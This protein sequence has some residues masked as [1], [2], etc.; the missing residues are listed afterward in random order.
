MVLGQLGPEFGAQH[1]LHFLQRGHSAQQPG[2]GTHGHGAAVGFGQRLN[3]HGFRLAVIASLSS[4]TALVAATLIYEWL[5][6][7][8]APKED[9][10]S[11]PQTNIAHRHAN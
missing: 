2:L 10:R 3:M 6:L 11:E 9:S 7:L 1:L 8:A 5:C 4:N